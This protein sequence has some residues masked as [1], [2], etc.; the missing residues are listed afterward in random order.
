VGCIAQ[1]FQD[2]GIVMSQNMGSI[3]Q[4]EINIFVLVDIPDMTPRPM[5]DEWRSTTDSLESPDRATDTAGKNL[6]AFIE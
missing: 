4:D 2:I 1:G 3:G 5:I 6:S